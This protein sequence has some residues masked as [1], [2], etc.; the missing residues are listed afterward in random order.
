MKQ[1]SRPDRPGRGTDRDEDEKGTEATAQPEA[2]KEVSAGENE[3]KEVKGT[4][5]AKGAKGSPG[6][7]QAPARDKVIGE[8]DMRSSAD[9]RTGVISGIKDFVM[10]RVTYSNVNGMGIFEGDIAL[11]TIAELDKTAA[12]ADSTG[13]ARSMP[14]SGTGGSGSAPAGVAMAVGVAD[15]RFLWP[16]GVVPY[17]FQPELAEIVNAAIQHWQ[18]RTRI[19][20]VERT[21]AN[22]ASHPNYVS[23]EVRDGCWSAVGMQG[24]QQIVSIGPGC[25]VGQ[26]I[27][28]IGHTVGLWHEQ[29]R[30]DRDQFVRIAWENII[31]DAIHNFD[32]H[33]TDGDDIGV[34][35]YASIMHYPP[36]AFSSNGEDTIVTLGGELV[37]QRMG[38]SDGDVAAV[39]ELYPEVLGTSHIYTASLIELANAVRDQGYRS[40]GIA[41]FALPLPLPGT[42]AL[43]RLAD[44]EGRRIYTASD[45]EAQDLASNEGYTDEGAACYVFATPALG[46]VPLLRLDNP[47]QN[48]HLFTT[49]LPEAQQ[50]MSRFGYVGHSVAAHVLSSFVPGTIP[51]FRLSKAA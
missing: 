17:D 47:S 28:E 11:G 19:R 24:G 51:F 21:P 1:P 20:F 13:L 27:H 32:Q 36:K 7:K 48:D 30:E 29:S 39:V 42:V 44:K 4:K 23:F 41:F 38:L 37:G 12:A 15:P 18:E 14:A 33:I 22:Q 16:G 9:K 35:D 46:L 8:C 26:A 45:A 40:D 43:R 3:A 6:A 50:A 5:E 49:S 2:E 10:K 31:P 25:G 34:Y